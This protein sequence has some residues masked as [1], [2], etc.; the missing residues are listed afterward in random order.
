MEKVVATV[1]QI[2]DC[3]FSAETKPKFI[4]GLRSVLQHIAAKPVDLVVVSGDIADDGCAM[5]YRQIKALC[6]GV[7]AGVP[8]VWVPGNHDDVD[9]IEMNL[10]RPLVTSWTRANWR[11]EFLN[12]AVPGKVWGRLGQDQLSRLQQSLAQYAETHVGVFMHHPPAAVGTE[13]IDPQCVRDADGLAEIIAS[14]RNVRWL[15]NG[16]VHQERDDRFAGI[17]WYCAPATSRQ[18]KA[19]AVDFELDKSLMPGYRRF[20]LLASGDYRTA[21]ERVSVIN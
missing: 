16:H 7:L 19:N 17:P 8:F 6:E 18:F 5:A 13:W 14:H 15:S 9:A 4:Q 10:Q 3:H 21:V 11:L 2:S 20:E 12:T 1:A